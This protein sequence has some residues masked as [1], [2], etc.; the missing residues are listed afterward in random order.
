M[1]SCSIAA[2]CHVMS[3]FFSDFVVKQEQ[4]EEEICPVCESKSFENL[5]GHYYCIE[6]GTQSQ[7]KNIIIII[8]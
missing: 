6:C 1:G 8:I 3:S 7:V 4:L 2:I 5:E